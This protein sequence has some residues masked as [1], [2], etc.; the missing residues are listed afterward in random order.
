MVARSRRCDNSRMSANKEVPIPAEALNA[1]DFVMNIVACTP[2]RMADIQGIVYVD[3][4]LHLDERGTVQDIEA[5]CHT[6]SGREIEPNDPEILEATRHALSVLR[7][8]PAR[9]RG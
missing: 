9:L 3:V 1:D 8:A 7:F 2:R 6:I 4:R 5:R